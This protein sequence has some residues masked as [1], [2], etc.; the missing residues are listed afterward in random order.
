M[1]LKSALIF[2]ALIALSTS[3]HLHLQQGNVIE[4]DTE[5]FSSQF[6]NLRTGRNI[7]YFSSPSVKHLFIIDTNP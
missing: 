7:F 6:N 2:L 1:M 5:D 3:L 4:M